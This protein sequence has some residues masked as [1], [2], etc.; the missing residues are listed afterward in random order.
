MTTKNHIHL[1]TNGDSALHEPRNGAILP[2]YDDLPSIP[3]LSQR[4]SWGVWDRY[5]GQSSNGPDDLGCLNLLTPSAK[6]AAAQEVST[7]ESFALNWKYE[8]LHS[9]R[10]RRSHRV[11]PLD[12]DGSEWVGN[13]DEVEFNTQGG[14][15][16]D[17]FREPCTLPDMWSAADSTVGH[18]AHQPSKLFY[19]GVSQADIHGTSCRNG[20][21]S[22]S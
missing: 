1:K 5:T 4:G 3:P 20:I 7:G 16:W 6:L 11:I 17:G 13:D 12:E 14:S 15:Q 9:G 19:N 10:R 18:W 21:D 2:L 8:A 22:E